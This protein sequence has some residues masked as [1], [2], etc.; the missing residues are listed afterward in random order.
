MGRRC[1]GSSAAGVA[2]L[3]TLTGTVIFGSGLAAQIP[4]EFTNLQHFSPDMPRQELIQEMRV[5]SLTLGVR[6]Q[7]CHVGSVD[8]TSFEGVDFASDESPRKVA[9]RSMLGMVQEINSR[10]SD[11]PDV[12]RARESVTCKSCHRRTSRP[13]LLWQFLAERLER[14]GPTS[15]EAAYA[16]ARSQLEAGRF[17]FEDEWELNMWAESLV[18]DERSAEAIS[19][20]ELNLTR[21]PESPGVLS[22]LGPLYEAADRDEDAIRVYRTFLAVQPGNQQVAARLRALTGG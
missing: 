18:A 14:D 3:L 2:A 6:C 17:D 8:G 21:F 11:L 10:V 4:Q 12:Q 16:Q 15:L 1:A 7:F 13:Q 20:L 9:A 5:M 22:A 19:V